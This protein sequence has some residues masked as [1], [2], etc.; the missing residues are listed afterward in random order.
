MYLA[1]AICYLTLLSCFE[2]RKHQ[3]ALY[4]DRNKNITIEIVVG[5]INCRFLVDTGSSLSLADPAYLPK[6]KWIDSNHTVAALSQFLQTS[7]EKSMK[8]IATIGIVDCFDNV[9]NIEV[10]L[11]SLGLKIFNF[12]NSDDKSPRIYGFI[13]ADFLIKH[14]AVIDYSSKTISFTTYEIKPKNEKS[15]RKK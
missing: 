8:A 1:L 2:P 6:F 7:Q 15:T 10:K 3:A 4:I 9:I 14:K 13:G 11:H 5:E 12:V